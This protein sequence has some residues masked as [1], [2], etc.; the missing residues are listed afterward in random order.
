M[1]TFEVEL[2]GQ[3]FEVDA[4][5]EA[6]AARAVRNMAGPTRTANLDMGT[7]NDAV[8][9]FAA[10]G[11]APPPLERS[12]AEPRQMGMGEDV[13]RSAASGVGQGVIGL[14]TTPGN[15]EAI[16]TRI[17]D[18][19]GEKTGSNIPGV[20]QRAIGLGSRLP[21]TAGANDPVAA[22]RQE[23]ERGPETAPV[24]QKGV[25]DVTGKFHKPQ[26]TAGEYAR[27]VGEFAPNLIFPGTAGQRVLNTVAP[28]IGNETAGQLTKGTPNEGIARFAG[29][30]LGPLAAK[31]ASSVVTPVP[32]HPVAIAES[33]ALRR[34]GVSHTAGQRTDNTFLK[35][36]ES[37]LGDSFG[38][39]G[40]ATAAQ[41]QSLEELTQAALARLQ[42]GN[43]LPPGAAVG[44]AG[45]DAMNN[46][47]ARIG[48]Q[49][50][51]LS[52]GHNIN[53][54]LLMR[55]QVAGAVRNYNNIVPPTLRSELVEGLHRDLTQSPTHGGP[56]L[57]SAQYQAIR[58]QIG[59]AARATGSSELRATLRQIQE[60]LDG[61][62]QRSLPQAQQ[63]A[64][65]EARREYRNLIVV[66]DAMTGAGQQTAQGLV[67]PSKL[68]AAVEEQNPRD[69][70]RGRGDFAELARAGAAVLPPLPQ[71][72]TAPR[73]A[74]LAAPAAI[75]AAIG[76]A[77]DGAQG[78]VVGS[79]VG[80]ASPAVA[81]RV[82]MN[83]LT[84][85][86]LGNQSLAD[87]RRNTSAAQ[88]AAVSLPQAVADAAAPSR[89]LSNNQTYR[90]LI[91]AGVPPEVAASAI[92]NPAVLSK[93]L[94]D[95]RG[96]QI[97]QSR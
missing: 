2:N 46:N 36:A 56:L 53:A 63:D 80:A 26:T 84:Q 15:S 50:D 35:Y 88:G 81:G 62:M 91:S 28:A 21:A 61:A 6:T 8:G 4:P 49:F 25:E 44:R 87:F 79:M 14:A 90:Y 82:I 69:Y 71:S 93:M 94:Q 89:D 78:S 34:A 24:M 97:E 5:D 70:I 29:T 68:R 77:L 95:L 92:G 45:S 39:G 65:R 33:D 31:A 19:I 12:S 13:V 85:Q 16:A 64:W 38:A 22:L 75:G 20:L 3:T 74:V 54:D 58:S 17:A 18:W 48:A 55:N 10:P 96:K 47:I 73:A 67:T 66:E 9:R 23:A 42:P 32:G 83:P 51:Q 11:L 72:G 43:V 52:A 76:S 7:M 41:T 86:Y 37:G 59:D 57:T 30:M 27:T 60:A 1:A 40:K